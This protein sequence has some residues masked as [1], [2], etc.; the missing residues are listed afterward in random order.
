MSAALALILF[1]AACGFGTAAG[2]QASGVT[3]VLNS[4]TAALSFRD[5]WAVR[6]YC[7]TWNAGM[8]LAWRQRY[9]WAAF[10]GPAGPQGQAS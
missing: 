9:G 8:P 7:A 1:V 2:Q 10:C 3:A 5:L 6:A 4:Y